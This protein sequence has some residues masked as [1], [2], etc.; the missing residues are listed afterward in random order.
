MTMKNSIPTKDE[1]ERN[2]PLILMPWVI[3]QSH[4]YWCC[5]ALYYICHPPNRSPPTRRNSIQL[6]TPHFSK[7]HGRARAFSDPTYQQA[8]PVFSVHDT[9]KDKPKQN[10][11]FMSTFQRRPYRTSD[12]LFRPT[13]QQE[14][15]GTTLPPVWIQKARHLMGS[16][17]ANLSEPTKSN[18]S[19]PTASSN[20][21]KRGPILLRK[22]N[23][24]NK[25][26]NL[27]KSK[28]TKKKKYLGLLK[29]TTIHPFN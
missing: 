2:L 19:G 21:S 24:K 6:S 22:L 23:K 8:A 28:D 13:M 25:D 16:S 27:V 5:S 4:I 3:L 20:D 18:L 12:D 11:R 1:G 17:P 26:Q 10:N 15:E 7:S 14:R 9:S 29:Q